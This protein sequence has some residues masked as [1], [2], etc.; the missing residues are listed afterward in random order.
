MNEIIEYKHKRACHPGEYVK[1]IIDD[2]G[3]TQDEFAFRMGVSGKCVSEIINRKCRITPELA[4]K[5]SAMTGM[6]SEVWMNL[7][8]VYDSKILE[9]NAE[10]DLDKQKSVLSKLDFTYFLRMT[11]SKVIKNAKDKIAFL[12]SLLSISSLENLQTEQAGCNFRFSTNE[13]DEINNI[14]ARAWLYFAWKK[15]SEVDID[16]TFNAELLESHLMEIRSMSCQGVAKSLPRLTEIFNECG[17]VFVPIPQLKNSKVNGVVKWFS[18]NKKVLLAI[19]DRMKTE[20]SFWFTLFH[21]IKHVLQRKFRMIIVS[22]DETPEQDPEMEEDA[23]QFAQEVLLPSTTYNYFV[24]KGDFSY[25]SIRKEAESEGIHPGIIAARLA[26][27]HYVKFKTISK[28][29]T[30]FSLNY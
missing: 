9:I 3:I 14:S 29:R 25:R 13:R 26:R 28:L 6:E 8:A 24:D 5:L 7:Q 15:A 18:N 23:D 16:T 27:D 12:C 21:E 2:M 1:D 22:V 10:I 11:G 4:G 19:N 30:S 17:V 20:D